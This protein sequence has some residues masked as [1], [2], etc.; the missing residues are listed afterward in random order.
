[1]ARWF[2][3]SPD[4]AARAARSAPLTAYAGP[5]AAAKPAG[6]ATTA[7]SGT[8][9]VTGAERNAPA[10]VKS[11]VAVYAA[12]VFTTAIRYWEP[13]W[14]VSWVAVPGALRNTADWPAV[15]SV[16]PPNPFSTSRVTAT[17]CGLLLAP[18]AVIGTPAV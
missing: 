7:G 2:C 10:S 6:G 17:C 4:A 18:V 8:S 12:P 15:A 1:M 13:A 9:R 14:S 16:V 11:S 5:C 3:T